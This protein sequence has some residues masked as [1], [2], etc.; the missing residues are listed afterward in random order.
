MDE[1]KYTPLRFIAT[2][3]HMFYSSNLRANLAQTSFANL[4]SKKVETVPTRTV[5]VGVVAPGNNK[6]LARAIPR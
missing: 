6:H 2:F 4:V 1:V 5:G 3:L